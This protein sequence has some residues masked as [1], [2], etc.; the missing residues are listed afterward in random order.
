MFDHV[1]CVLGVFANKYIRPGVGLRPTFLA[2]PGLYGFFIFVVENAEEAFVFAFSSPKLS[3]L[4]GFADAEVAPKSP[5]GCA[6]TRA[7]ASVCAFVCVS[8]CACAYVRLKLRLP[9]FY[10]QTLVRTPVW[11][12]VCAGVRS[13]ANRQFCCT[14]RIRAVQACQFG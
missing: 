2:P 6:R 4:T 11:G 1:H 5:I 13:C 8:G 7:R 14:L 10:H 3:V 12:C 9:G